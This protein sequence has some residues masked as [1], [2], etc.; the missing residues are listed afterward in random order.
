VAKKKKHKLH[1]G[2][3][4]QPDPRRAVLK[5]GRVQIEWGPDAGL[6]DAMPLAAGQASEPLSVGLNL[7]GQA[8]KDG[9]TLSFPTESLLALTQVARRD[10]M[11]RVLSDEELRALTP[12]GIHMVMAPYRVGEPGREPFVRGYVYMMRQDGGPERPYVRWLDFPLRAVLTAVEAASRRGMMRQVGDVAKLTQP[13]QA[14][15]WAGSLAFERAWAKLMPVV[16]D[17]EFTRGEN[18]DPQALMAATLMQSMEAAHLLKLDP[19]QF[20]VRPPW[21]QPSAA[22]EYAVDANLPFP[23]VFYEF[24][25]PAGYSP[26]ITGATS[27]LGSD[28]YPINLAAAIVR[29]DF[30][31]R[32]VVEPLIVGPNGWPDVLP[33]GTIVFGE[34]GE[35]YEERDGVA[36]VLQSLAGVTS[37]SCGVRLETLMPDSPVKGWVLFPGTR[38]EVE[39]D[40]PG[41][42]TAVLESART[43]LY[44]GSRVL[45][46]LSILDAEVVEIVEAPLER[47]EQRRQEKRGWRISL[48]VRI[49]APKKYRNGNAPT[50]EEAHYS[51]RFWVVGHTKHFGV[52]T[53]MAMARPDLVRPCLRCG[54]CRRIWTPPFVKGPPDKPLILKSLVADDRLKARRD[55]YGDTPIDPAAGA[56]Q[57]A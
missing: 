5:G 20:K 3:P 15:R 10:G 54:A 6:R 48:I 41:G 40:F 25:G 24:T 29:R 39:R 8:A 52:A 50:G 44:I 51:H 4:S 27:G 47:R 42:A 2:Q 36:E 26:R 35:E 22:Y 28:E 19:E 1:G 30:L 18:A 17:A 57:V 38:D 43:M 12:G 11:E 46:A 31:N 16:R 13:R 49:R 9:L 21:E 37:I 32:L 55:A 45:A 7:G 33:V 34:G 56:G 23:T 14:P 53:Q